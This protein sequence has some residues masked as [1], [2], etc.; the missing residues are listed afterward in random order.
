MADRRSGKSSKPS[1][2]PEEPGFHPGILATRSIST[3]A[4]LGSAATWTVEQAVIGA[5]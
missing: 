5:P 1:T 3:N 2:C 4:F